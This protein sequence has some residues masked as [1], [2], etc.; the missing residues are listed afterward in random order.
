MNFIAFKKYFQITNKNIIFLIVVYKVVFLLLLL[1]VSG[2]FDSFRIGFVG[3][4]VRMQVVRQSVPVETEFKETHPRGPLR[5][6]AATR[7]SPVRYE[8]QAHQPPEQ[9]R[10]TLSAHR[11]RRQSNNVRVHVRIVV[12]RAAYT[13]TATPV[14]RRVTHHRRV[15]DHDHH[16]YRFHHVAVAD[17]T[18]FAFEKSKLVP[19]LEF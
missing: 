17:H 1:C 16:R 5:Q 8:L 11:V 18:S 6:R 10:Y 4:K 2:T 3:R 7:L 19:K 9:A 12:H 14:P 13:E 15:H